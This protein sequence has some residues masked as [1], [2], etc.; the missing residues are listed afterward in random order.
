MA[1]CPPVPGALQVLPGPAGLATLHLDRSEARPLLASSSHN[2][3]VPHT[4]QIF[5]NLCPSYPA[6]QVH[7]LSPGAAL[8]SPC[9]FFPGQVPDP[10]S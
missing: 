6:S 5:P 3:P 1:L 4:S 10:V 9:P 2:F 7:L 8:P